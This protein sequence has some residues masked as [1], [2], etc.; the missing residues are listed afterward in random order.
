MKISE[1]GVDE[2]IAINV[3]SKFS[4]YDPVEFFKSKSA[5]NF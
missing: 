1:S 4:N 5:E 3:C 2:K